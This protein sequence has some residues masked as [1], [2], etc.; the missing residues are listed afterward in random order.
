MARCYTVGECEVRPEERRVLAK[1]QPAVIG[2]RAFDLL[3]CLIEHRDRVVT[4][5]E[6]MKLVWPGLVVEENNLTVH[7]SALRKLLGAQAVATVPGRGYRFT[8]QVRESGTDTLTAMQQAAMTST[9]D[10][11]PATTTVPGETALPLSDKPS[12][13]VLPFENMSGDPSQAHIADGLTEDLITALSRYR[14][15]R[16][17]ARHSS[18]AFK[19]R[20]EDVR[21]AA[22]EL[23]ANYIVEGSV[24]RAG[25]RLRMTAQ[26]L[27]GVTGGHLWAERYDRELEDLFALQDEISA[28]IAG[29][30]E[31]ELGMAERQ[32]AIRRPTQNP[33]AWDC[34]HLGLSHMYRFAQESNAEAQRLFQHAIELDPQFAQAHARLA[35]CKIL[36]MIYFDASPMPEALDEALRLAQNA[37]VL[38]PDEAFCHMAVGRVRIARREYELGL[39]GCRA[40]IAMNPTM[41]VAYCAMG[42]ALAY[43]GRLAEAAPYFEKAIRMS[44]N[45]PWRWAFYAYEALALFLGGRLKKAVEQ[46]QKAILTPNCQYWARAHLAVALAYL[47]RSDEAAATVAELK[48]Q[49]PGFSLPFAREKLFYLESSEQIERY[50]DGLR[51]AGVRD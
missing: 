47:G 12:I 37:V 27:D 50:I 38:D 28:M 43:S 5:D 25:N 33:G 36:D 35:Y 20:G 1:G 11:A 17:L 34:Y 3:M 44:P 26:L 21:Q 46:A 24:R 19:G 45:D 30:I 8:M 22:K 16:V 2:A 40:A 49:K 18:F 7:V 4:K 10:P 9:P 32:R 6:L 29:R 39:A 48:R 15:L 42:D 14:W 51:R 23:E 13:A 41:G 31:P